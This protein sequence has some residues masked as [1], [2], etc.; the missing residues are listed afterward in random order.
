MVC[1]SLVN[2]FSLSSKLSHFSIVSLNLAFI[3]LI[4]NQITHCYLFFFFNLCDFIIN[5]TGCTSKI[6]S[7][8][9]L[10]FLFL[11]GQFYFP[12]RCV[13]I[14][15]GWSADKNTGERV[16]N[17][18]KC[19]TEHDGL[20]ILN[21]KNTSSCSASIFSSWQESPSHSYCTI[22]PSVLLATRRCT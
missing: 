14:P 15:V 10:L 19:G 12:S 17:V 21:L 9:L 8:P 11:D 7:L 18:I 4:W 20:I 13:V 16:V 6:R 1:F 5:D 2:S 22:L 3:L